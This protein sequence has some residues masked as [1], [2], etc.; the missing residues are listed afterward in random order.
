YYLAYHK[1][2][3]LEQRTMNLPHLNVDQLRKYYQQGF[4]T[5][6]QRPRP[7]AQK[8]SESTLMEALARRRLKEQALA[9]LPMINCCICGAPSCK[10]L[11]DDISRGEAK[12]TDC[13][14]YSSEKLEELK[15]I[16]GLS[17]DLPHD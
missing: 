16:Y 3:L 15:R 7:G 17:G 14:F 9:A 11:A 8:G 4:F 12:L 6:D 1:I 5:L 10:C 13:V 2:I